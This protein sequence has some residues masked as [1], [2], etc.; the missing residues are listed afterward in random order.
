MKDG[1]VQEDSHG[2]NSLEPPIGNFAASW[3]HDISLFRDFFL[4][5][6]SDGYQNACFSVD[7]GLPACWSSPKARCASDDAS[8]RTSR[9]TTSHDTN[10]THHTQLSQHPYETVNRRR[11]KSVAVAVGFNNAFDPDGRPIVVTPTGSRISKD[12]T[13]VGRRSPS[14][15]SPT[16]SRLGSKRLAPVQPRIITETPTSPISPVPSHY[17][18]RENPRSTR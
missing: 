12:L 5:A 4:A 16:F 17:L 9:S 10:S 15:S 3:I 7:D 6:F 1:L 8:L 11:K 13:D 18:T 2:T 14:G